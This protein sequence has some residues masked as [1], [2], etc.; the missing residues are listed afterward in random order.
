MLEK[1]LKKA[2]FCF[3]SLPPSQQ[4]VSHVGTHLSGLAVDNV[5]CSW[6]QNSFAWFEVLGLSQQ[7]WSCQNGQFK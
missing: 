2:C 7:L 4:I 1:W 5:S 3:D 6:T